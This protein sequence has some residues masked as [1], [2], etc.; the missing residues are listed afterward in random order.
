MPAA[1]RVA[2]KVTNTCATG[3]PIGARAPRRSSG[4]RSDAAYGTSGTIVNLAASS[5]RVL[6]DEPP[7]RD[8]PLTLRR[9]AR[10]RRSASAG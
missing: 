4:G 8:E 7:Q 1:V 5:A 2:G 9:P 6:R 10:G 3:A